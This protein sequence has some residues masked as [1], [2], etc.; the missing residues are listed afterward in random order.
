MASVKREGCQALPL[1]AYARKPSRSVK[2]GRLFDLRGLGC[3]HSDF[4]V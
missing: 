2:G 4:D 1:I 3:V